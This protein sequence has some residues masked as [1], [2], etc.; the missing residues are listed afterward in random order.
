VEED[1]YMRELEAKFYERK[2]T[3]AKQEM[4]AQE[5]KHYWETIAPV[6]AE[7]QDVL[8]ATGDDA[9]SISNA[10]LEALARWKLGLK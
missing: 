5:L 7:M 10:G 9:G 1:R 6:M 3:E 8:K 2:R 4:A